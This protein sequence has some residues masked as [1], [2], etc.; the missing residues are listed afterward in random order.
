MSTDDSISGCALA[1]VA[2]GDQSA[3]KALYARQVPW[4]CTY[5]SP[6]ANPRIAITIG[7]N[8]AQSN[9]PRLLLEVCCVLVGR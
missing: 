2:R 3:M 7:A 6:E 4:S 1:G 8:A 9:P 5:I